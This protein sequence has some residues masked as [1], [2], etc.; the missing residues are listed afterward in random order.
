MNAGGDDDA[1]LKRVRRVRFIVILFSFSR[2]VADVLLSFY[3]RQFHK[4]F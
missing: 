3:F 4:S 2:L 1:P